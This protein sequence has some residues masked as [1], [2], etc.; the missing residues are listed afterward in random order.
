MLLANFNRKEHLRHRAVS[1]RQHGFLVCIYL[2]VSTYVAKS[3]AYEL[4]CRSETARRH[5]FGVDLSSMMFWSAKSEQPSLTNSVV[6]VEVFHLWNKLPFS[7]RQPHSVHPTP[8]S[9]SCRLRISPHHSHHL[10]W[11]HLSLPRSFTPDLKLISF[12]NPFLHSHS[13]SFRT[14]ST[15][16]EPVLN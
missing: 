4:S 6:I 16:I 7:F 1:L 8:G 13:D 14:A 10:C 9:P 3:D 2:Y 11:H 5:S 15:V 12:T